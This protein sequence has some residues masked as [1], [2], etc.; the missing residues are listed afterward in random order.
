MGWEKILLNPK[1]AGAVKKFFNKGKVSNTITSV[2]PKLTKGEST[3]VW[4]QKLRG[5]FK[6][7][8]ETSVEDIDKILTKSGQLLQKVKGEKITKSGIS[9]SKDIK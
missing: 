1:T 8:L 6:K 3:K 2:T 7:K 9:K 5:K 4:G